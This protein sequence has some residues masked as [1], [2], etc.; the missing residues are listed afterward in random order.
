MHKHTYVHV[1]TPLALLK[2]H[3]G[4]FLVKKQCVFVPE[5]FKKIVTNSKEENKKYPYFPT[6]LSS[7][8]AQEKMMKNFKKVINLFLQ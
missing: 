3:T 2:D 6:N 5:Q 8:F 1:H 4:F 7:K